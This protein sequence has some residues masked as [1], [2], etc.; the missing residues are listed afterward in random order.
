MPRRD[1]GF[2]LLE[3]L[4][5]VAVLG[6]GLGLVV[7]RGPV[8][9]PTLALQAAVSEVAQGMRAARS[10]AIATNVPVRFIVNTAL[11][12]IRIDGDAPTV[13]RQP[14]ALSV[15]AVSDEAPGGSSAAIRFYGDGSASGG[16]V[17]I[18]DGQRHAQ[19]G[20]DWL[21]GRVSTLQ[22]P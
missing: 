17:E 8:R 15:I 16:R 10:R 14:L 20:V 21:T 2:T 11:C 12:S 9:S 13:L 7:T 19:V 4:V 22:A 5:V 18:T 3:M 6:L 1:G